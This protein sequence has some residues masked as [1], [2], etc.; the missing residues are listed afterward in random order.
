MLGLA[1]PAKAV[2]APFFGIDVE[3]STTGLRELN[4]KQVLKR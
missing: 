4:K 3:D 1:G 2:D